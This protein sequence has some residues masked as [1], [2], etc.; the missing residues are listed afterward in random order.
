M[1]KQLKKIEI[2]TFVIILVQ[3]AVYATFSTFYFADLLGAKNFFDQNLSI[4]FFT[5]AALAILNIITTLATIYGFVKARHKSDLKAADLLGDDIQEAYNFGM[6]GLVIVD[7]HNMV[8]WTNELFRDRKIDILD[9][10][11]LEWQPKLSDLQG[12]A[13]DSSTKVEIE[14]RYY[15]VK[16][17]DDAGLYIFKDVTELEISEQTQKREAV[18]VG[19][20]MID[21]YSN[22]SENADDAN[23][24]IS[25]VR[26]EI[27]EYFKDMNVAIRRSKAD[28]YFM[29]CNYESLEKMKNDKFSII[30]RIRELGEKEPV[31]PTLSIG[32]AHDFPGILKLSDMASSALETCMA[33]GGDQVV[34]SKFGEDLLYYG[35]KTRAT[36]SRNKVKVRVVSDT[37]VSLIKNSGTVLIMGHTSTDMDAIGSCLG[38]KAICD[39]CNVKSWVVYN[40]RAT[41]TK[42]RGAMTNSFTR[43]QLADITLSSSDSIEIAKTKSNVLLIV[44]DV[45]D[46]TRVVEPKLIEM[47]D[48]IAI[49]DHHRKSEK[50][51]DNNIF[52]HIDVSA[53]SASEIVTEFIHYSFSNPKI[54]L[55]ASYATI[56][57]SGIFLDSNFFKSKSTSTNA[58]EAAMVLKEYGADNFKADEFLKDEYEEV[59]LVNKIA[60]TMY[61]PF[62]G[63]VICKSDENDIIEPA[64]LSKV[65][66]HCMEMKGINAAF[67]IGKC[68][69]RKVRISCRS[70]G[71]ISVQILAE[72]LGGGG[73]QQSAATEMSNVSIEEAE[74]R[75][76]NVLKENLSDARVNSFEVK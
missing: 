37:L 8:L 10:N 48:K 65:A 14:N 35:G 64:T 22:I 60:S 25:K 29:V 76:N 31:P 17:L 19:Y 49:I 4:V 2:F 34:V 6:I 57:L 43:E 13:F 52:S 46:P 3:L 63:V 26:N 72:K 66:N 53:S 5:L 61:S 58:F 23:D 40:P 55:P 54:K 30:D 42:A 50:Y 18:V 59:A 47:I 44:T 62:Y 73:H 33:R 67:V 11:I 38:I 75:L 28:T 51:I 39:F 20:V 74:E 69:E 7:E 71:T 70:D 56:M 12:T 45:S 41:E 15:S 1:N 32:I 9:K 27:F 36:E 24:V 21:N 68:D 16:F